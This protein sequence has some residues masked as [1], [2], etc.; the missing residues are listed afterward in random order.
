M[1]WFLGEESARVGRQH[2]AEP[3][4]SG[5]KSSGR[6][7]FFP[8]GNSRIALREAPKQCTRRA[9]R[10]EAM[11]LPE[12]TR[13]VGDQRMVRSRGLLGLLRSGSF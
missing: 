1:E 9:A 5:S 2:R 11:A 6:R 7:R 12:N 4:S 13:G 10:R 8:L 3:Q